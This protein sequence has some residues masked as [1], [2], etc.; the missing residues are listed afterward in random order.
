MQNVMT[1]KRTIADSNV[2]TNPCRNHHNCLPSL[3]VQTPMYD[4]NQQ[5]LY[6]PKV[7]DTPRNASSKTKRR[8]FFP[9]SPRSV[10]QHDRSIPFR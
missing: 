1:R 6:C 10:V 7:P 2:K 8:M 5:R 3:T 4:D 9:V